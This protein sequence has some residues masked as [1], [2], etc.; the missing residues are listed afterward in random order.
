[1]RLKKILRRA[2]ITLVVLVLLTMRIS[3][4]FQ[5]IPAGY[6]GVI[7]SARAGLKHEAIKP[8]AKFVGFWEQLYVYPT[9]LQA[10][11]Y[12]ES[13][14]HG[15]VSSADG[16]QITTNDAANTVF[17]VTVFYR[18]KPE[19][20]FTLFDKFGPISI[21]E[22]QSLHIRRAVREG[23]SIVGN[24]F[25]VFQLMGT[26]REEASTL[27][28]EELRNRLGPRGLT[29]E[30]AMINTAFP[31]NEIQQKIASRVNAY[32]QLEIA[33]LESQIAE[34]QR[35]S[36]VVRG[37]AENDARKL[38]ASQTMDKSIDMLKLELEEAAI[39]KW[40]AAGGRLSPI[41]VR[42]GQS[43]IVNGSG[44]PVIPGGK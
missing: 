7:Y 12:T 8:Q 2:A 11:I 36:A 27:L 4:R 24:R 30:I 43:I 26:K 37:A 35:Q 16:I 22:I 13:P 9:R 25:D 3:S 40:K 39:E 14:A 32:T 23:A 15:E 29:I 6:V 34:V 31:T 28:T 19:D 21:E 33:K 17:D 20:V 41:I 38:T 44:A 42:P 10:A 18:V 5:W 1:M